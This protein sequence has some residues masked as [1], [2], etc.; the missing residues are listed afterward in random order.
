MIRHGQAGLR[1]NY[2]TLSDLGREQ[3]RRL[4][5][6]LA[7]QH[8]CFG[9]MYVGGLERQRETAELVGEEYRAAGGAL[10]D[11]IDEPGWSEFDL[12]GVMRELVP[13]LSADDPEFAVESEK[14]QRAVA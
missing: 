2:D 10:P 11:F 7:E 9:A 3:S 13:R 4:G 6:Y 1:Q 8:I 12:D 14:Q 5:R